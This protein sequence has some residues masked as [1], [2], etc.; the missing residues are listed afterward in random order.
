MRKMILTLLAAASL[1]ACN[2]EENIHMP[3]PQ[4]IAFDNAFVYKTRAAA[5]PSITTNGD[6]GTTPITAFK[7]WAFMDSPEAIVLADELVEKEENLWTYKNVQY[8][9]PGHIYY[10][11]A[12]APVEG[13]AWTLDT[14]NANTFGVGTLSFTNDNGDQ[15]LLYAATSVS[16]EEIDKGYDMP[17]VKLFFS[18]L[19]SKVKFTFTNGFETDN[20][21]MKV[22]NIQMT[23]PKSGTINLA[24]ENWWDNDGDWALGQDN[25][26]LAFGDV[27][28][29]GKGATAECADARLTIPAHKDHTYAISFDV[30]VFVSGKSAYK[31][32]KT[33]TLTGQ[34]IEMGKSYNFTAAITPK[35]LE[36]DKIEFEV[37]VKDWVVEAGDVPVLQ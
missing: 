22:T 13:A 21:T 17:A 29:L 10:F 2:N 28:T 19:L 9:M 25:V 30:E 14:K 7:A 1:V 5:D 34:A 27:E 23:A 33:T 12:V 18:H 20:I 16:T 32:T 35:N 11:G 26:Q 31:V 6:N 36:L 37:V 3:S 8:W 15:D 4:A 24:V